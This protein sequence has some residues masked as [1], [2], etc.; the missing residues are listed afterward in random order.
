MDLHMTLRDRMRSHRFLS[1]ILVVA[2]LF[3]GIL[4]GT[5]IQRGVKGATRAVNSSDATPLKVPAPQQLSSAFSQVAKQLEPSV[6]NVNTESTPKS[7][8]PRGRRRSNPDGEDNQD[9]FQD[10][11]DRFFGGQ[12]GSPFGGPGGGGAT[13]HSLGSGVIVDPKGYIIT[14]QHVVEKA[15]RIRV[16]LDGDPR[17][18]NMTQKSWARIRRQIWRSSK[19]RSITP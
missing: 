9:P 3:V 1:T 19:L 2:T 8:T 14:N 12:G 18:C 7:V 13:E 15:D 17:A 16:K 5:I 6:V 4:I 11:F 10:F